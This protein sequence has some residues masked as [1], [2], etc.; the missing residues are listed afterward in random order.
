MPCHIDTIVRIKQVRLTDREDLNLTI[1][2]A[3]GLYPLESEDREL[4]LVLFVPLKEDERDPNIQSIFVKD[5]YYC[6]S[7]KVVPENINDNFKLKMTVSTSTHINIKRDLGSNWCPL[8]VSLVGIA[9][10]VMKEFN[11]ESA[12]VNILV[13]DYAGQKKYSFVVK[14]V[15]P[16]QN[17]GNLYANAVDISYVDVPS[18]IKKKV[19]DSISSQISSDCYSSVRSKLLIAHQSA[20]EGL[21]K[22]LV[23]E[24]SDGV[25]SVVDSTVGNSNFLKLD[26]EADEYV[27]YVDLDCNEDK[28]VI[29]HN[30]ECVEGSSRC[31]EKFLIKLM[32]ISILIKRQVR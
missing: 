23:V 20:C 7:G 27:E 9:Q 21:D 1:V 22:V 30:D 15:F 25:G 32:K 26:D 24:G 12:L 18:V 16:Y 8:K 17:I 29:E 5:E 10:D 6:I 3:I 31:G 19:S 28:C 13:R 11:K 14:I 2:W 4:D